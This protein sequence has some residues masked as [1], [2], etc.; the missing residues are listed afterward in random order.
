MSQKLKPNCATVIIICSPKSTDKLSLYNSL[1]TTFKWPV[2]ISYNIFLFSNIDI[3][4]KNPLL[5]RLNL[6][7]L[8][9]M[10]FMHFDR[11]HAEF[12]FILNNLALKL[13]WKAWKRPKF[14]LWGFSIWQTVFSLCLTW[15]FS[16][17]LLDSN[18]RVRMTHIKET[19]KEMLTPDSSSLMAH[20]RMCVCVCV[21]ACS[22]ALVLSYLLTVIQKRTD[23]Q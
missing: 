13:N 11:F 8:S 10:H 14:E 7:Q 19:V 9:D 20:I 4:L 3:G 1:I 23:T 5:V 12:S 15:S 17:F 21:L 6:A 16:V 2:N 18:S 22:L